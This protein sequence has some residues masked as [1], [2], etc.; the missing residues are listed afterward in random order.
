M[1]H[2]LL[3]ALGALPQAMSFRDA[4]A[5]FASQALDGQ[6][7]APTVFAASRAGAVGPRHLTDWG[8]IADAIV[9]AVRD[10]VW[11]QWTEGQREHVRLAAQQAIA[12]TRPLAREAAL[13]MQLLAAER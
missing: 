10:A 9:F 3:L 13:Q 12:E 1:L 7:G 11:R 8:G 5:A 4:Q 6:E 2:D